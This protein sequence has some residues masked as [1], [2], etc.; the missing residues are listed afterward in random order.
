[1]SI[2]RWVIKRHREAYNS[3]VLSDEEG[4]PSTTKQ[5]AKNSSPEATEKI[6]DTGGDNPCDQQTKAEEDDVR[7]SMEAAEN[8]TAAE[9]KAGDGSLPPPLTLPVIVAKE[10]R[11]PRR[12]AI[13]SISNS[14]S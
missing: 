11:S 5:L 1:M 10:Q 14:S 4:E 7:K 6:T 12:G 13:Q 2:I 3:E 9:G 8:K